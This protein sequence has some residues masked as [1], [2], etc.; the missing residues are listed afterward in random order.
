[1]KRLI[2]GIKAAW[3]NAPTGPT[4]TDEEALSAHLKN[5]FNEPEEVLR[6]IRPR[7]AA[8]ALAKAEFYRW[9]ASE[10]ASD[11]PHEQ[12]LEAAIA[13][14]SGLI[15]A[16]PAT[17]AVDPDA[18]LLR[19]FAEYQAARAAL[20]AWAD[21]SELETPNKLWEISEAAEERVLGMPANS[22]AGLAAQLRVLW[23]NQANTWD[24]GRHGVQHD[25]APDLKALW[26][27]IERAKQ[28]SDGQVPTTPPAK[29]H[30][31]AELLALGDE[32]LAAR[33]AIRDWQGEPPEEV[34]QRKDDIEDR[35]RALKAKT[36]AGLA[37]QIMVETDAATPNDMDLRALEIGRG[38]NASD[39]VPSKE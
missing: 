6:N 26:S 15:E 14:L 36:A 18:E 11:D 13:D 35:I 38:I 7:T 4:K 2:T 30:V 3:N 33:S 17:V 24:E 23:N 21:A 20:H 28:L 12:G 34:Y 10:S 31:D 39:Y 16:A 5:H 1:L 29:D 37:I 8:G 25:S 27:I 9:W 19:A 32:Y 22:Y